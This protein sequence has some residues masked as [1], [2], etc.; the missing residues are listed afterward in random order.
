MR[1]FL[2]V[3][4]VAVALL[5]SATVNEAKAFDSSLMTGAT[6][7]STPLLGAGL[8]ALTTGGAIYLVYQDISN[9]G[10]TR[11]YAEAVPGAGYQAR[12]YA[13]AAKLT[14]EFN[15]AMGYADDAQTTRFLASA[16]R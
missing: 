15:V 10:L 5:A 9:G 8:F 2:T 1:K 13:N 3:A 16:T 11:K 4:A 7:A 14:H 6:G 12:D